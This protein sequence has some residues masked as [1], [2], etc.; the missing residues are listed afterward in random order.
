MKVNST[1]LKSVVNKRGALQSRTYE[2][3]VENHYVDGR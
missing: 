3:P 2:D 1:G